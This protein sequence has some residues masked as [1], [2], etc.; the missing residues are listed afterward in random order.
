MDYKEEIKNGIDQLLSGE[1]SVLA[2][3]RVFYWFYLEIVP[4]EFLSNEEWALCTAI[5]RALDCI[6]VATDEQEF[7]EWVWNLVQE[8]GSQSFCLN[9]S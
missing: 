2:F 7:I 6:A 1:L 8:G 3:K 4:G 5:D 9:P